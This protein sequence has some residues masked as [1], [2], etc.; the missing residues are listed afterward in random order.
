MHAH[1]VPLVDYYFVRPGGSL[2]LSASVNQ[3]AQFSLNIKEDLI[4]GED[5]ETFKIKLTLQSALPNDAIIRDSLSIV[6]IDS[7]GQLM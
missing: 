7:D 5:E 6:I 3:A 4:V 1:S 2:T